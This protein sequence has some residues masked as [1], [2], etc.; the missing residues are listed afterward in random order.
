MAR[1]RLYTRFSEI[2]PNFKGAPHNNFPELKYDVIWTRRALDC[3]KILVVT[4]V[5]AGLAP[6]VVAAAQS[7]GSAT[8]NTR[9]GHS[10]TG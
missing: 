1:V 2:S 8:Q 9:E 6:V 10:I 7:R 5:V 4:V 3:E